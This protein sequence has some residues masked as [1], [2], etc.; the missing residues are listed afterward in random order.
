ME[1]DIADDID[2]L[3]KSSLGKLDDPPYVSLAKSSNFRRIPIKIP[4]IHRLGNK[5]KPKKGSISIPED[6]APVRSRSSA[7]KKDLIRV[8]GKMKDAPAVASV[9]SVASFS[10]PPPVIQGIQYKSRREDGSIVSSRKQKD[11]ELD[12]TLENQK[13]NDV[14]DAIDR[15]TS[16]AMKAI[17]SEFCPVLEA[18]NESK[19]KDPAMEG[20]V[21]AHVP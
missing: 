16:M 19:V 13:R 11:A 6:T 21:T 5:S 9:A 3:P 20:T 15:G 1:D 4:I 12:I 2:P 17:I 7:K 10:P 14:F 18:T 8:S